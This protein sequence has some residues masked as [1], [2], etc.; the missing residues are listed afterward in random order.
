MRNHGPI[1]IPHPTP[2]VNVYRVTLVIT[3]TTVRSLLDGSVFRLD[4]RAVG[5]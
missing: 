3:G 4:T 1:I 2:I 5:G